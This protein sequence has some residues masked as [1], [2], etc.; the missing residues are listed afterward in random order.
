MPQGRE[1]WRLSARV[2]ALGEDAEGVDYGEFVKELKASRRP[3]VWSPTSS[4]T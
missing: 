2:A 4:A 1:L 3:G